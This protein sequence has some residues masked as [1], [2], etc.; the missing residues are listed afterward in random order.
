MDICSTGYSKIRIKYWWLR[1]P[2]TAWDD[3]AYY[4]WPSGFVDFDDGYYVYHSYG[5][6]HSP[7]RGNSYSAWDVRP[8]G[9]V[10][11]DYDFVSYSYGRVNCRTVIIRMKRSMHLEFHLPE[12]SMVEIG[13]SLLVPTVFDMI[14]P[15]IPIK[16]L[17]VKIAGHA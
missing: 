8:S 15:K 1:S 12:I 11:N 9:D 6:I 7:F 10:G 14:R 17:V 5:R 16:L 2:G 3:Y 4:V 13:Y